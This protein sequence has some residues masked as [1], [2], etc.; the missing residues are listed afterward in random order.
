MATFEEIEAE[1]GEALDVTSARFAR[2]SIGEMRAAIRKQFDAATLEGFRI[3]WREVEAV[4]H[5]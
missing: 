2:L 4:H 5:G 3:E 1:T